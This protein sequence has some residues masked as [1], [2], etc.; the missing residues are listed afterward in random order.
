[1][2]QSKQR[3][4]VMVAIVAGTGALFV[5]PAGAE[6]DTQAPTRSLPP[7]ETLQPGEDLTLDQ[8][9]PV[10]VVLVGYDKKEVGRKLL[11]QLPDEAEPVVRYPRFYGLEGRPL[12]LNYDYDYRLVDTP[13]RFENR[14]FGNLRRIGETTPRTEYQTMYNDQRKNRLEIPKRVLTIDAEATERYLQRSAARQLGVRT[15]KGYTVFLV[16]WW[17]R[18]DFRFHVYRKRDGLDPDTG[19]DFAERDSRAM[20]AWGGSSGRTWFYDLSAGP[21][22]WTNNWNVDDVDLDEDQVPDYRMP[23]IWEYAKDGYRDRHALPVDLGK[24]VRYV[25]IDLLFTPSPLFDPLASAPDAGG[26]QRLVLTVFEGDPASS[27]VDRVDLRFTLA[28]LRRVQP[29]LRWRGKLRDLD[30]IPTE[31][32]DALDIFAGNSDDPGCAEPFGDPFAELF[33]FFDENRSDYLP[34]EGR[35]NVIGAFAFNTTDE[36]MGEW[37]GLLGFADD[38]WV[39]GTPSYVFLFDYPDAVDAGFGFT[40]TLVHEVGHHIGLSHPHDGFDPETGV[41]F[42]A[43]GEFYFT[44]SGDESDSVM[45]YLGLSN[46]FSVF[47][48]DNLSRWNAA[49]YLNWANELLAELDPAVLTRADRQKLRRADALATR[50]VDSFADWRY[51]T[52]ATHARHAWTLVREV[53]RQQDIDLGATA[54]AEETRRGARSTGEPPKP[55]PIRFPDD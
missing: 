43:V 34:P 27:G 46:N 50:S 49:G 6:T 2:R 26:D 3:V 10:N 17:G 39:S 51:V 45:H 37:L 54:F 42:G 5:G 41:D 40:S 14:F 9:I 13:K 8:D 20:I 33:C 44:W 11:S 7:L 38:D 30:P 35:D 22:A 32:Q 52:A 19:A 1:M 18:D 53:A 15:A 55:D 48:R 12:G 29:Y 21:E 24:V 23:P 31:V 36:S 4:A 28:Q 47:D 16:N 25:A